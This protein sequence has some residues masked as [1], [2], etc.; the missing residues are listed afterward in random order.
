[1]KPDQVLS[2]PNMRQI[3]RPK[4]AQ[5]QLFMHLYLVMNIQFNERKNLKKFLS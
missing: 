5:N 4:L 2:H 3:T 1:M